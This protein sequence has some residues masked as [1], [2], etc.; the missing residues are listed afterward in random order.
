MNL[1]ARLCVL[2]LLSVDDRARFLSWLLLI[3]REVGGFGV[4]MSGVPP[5]WTI[6]LFEALQKEVE[7]I[8]RSR[9][10]LHT[11][12]AQ[13]GTQPQQPGAPPQARRY[14]VSGT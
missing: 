2:L 9:E 11:S 13:R 10:V 5:E 6:L 3:V 8:A 7:I 4:A 14:R 12:E 1:S